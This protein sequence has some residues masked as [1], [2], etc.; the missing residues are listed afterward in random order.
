MGNYRI[1]IGNTLVHDIKSDEAVIVIDNLRASSTIVTALS[2]GIEEI[3]PV[4]DDQEA[5]L[6]QE[7]G[8]VI[9]GESDGFKLDGYD[10]GNS[11]I[12]LTNIFKRSPFTKLALKTSNLI[13]LLACLPQAYIC[14]SLN[15]E[16]ISKYLAGKDACIIAVAG[17]R[18]AVEDLGVAFA[19]V[20][21]MTGISFER[22]LITCFARESN[23]AKHLGEIGY[24][25]DIDFISRVNALNIIPYYD[26]KKIIRVSTN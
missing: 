24:K 5:F 17:E 3:I 25:H 1:G 12:E 6:L 16:S 10:I 4:L 13:P 8:I 15:L 7:N 9:A 23:A 26:G 19:L 20:A 14:S 18:G 11:P 21:C 22:D 2:L